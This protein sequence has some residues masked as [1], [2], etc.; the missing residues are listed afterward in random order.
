MDPR[1][2][3]RAVLDLVTLLCM[4]AYG[5]EGVTLQHVRSGAYNASG[6]HNLRLDSVQE[7]ETLLEVAK[8][9]LKAADERRVAIND[10]CKTLVTLTTLLLAV[11]GVLLPRPADV[12]SW[13][14]R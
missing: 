12:H 5:L 9:T 14:H 10:K 7:L 3:M 13:W 11:V 6:F 8:D 1:G 2:G 4:R